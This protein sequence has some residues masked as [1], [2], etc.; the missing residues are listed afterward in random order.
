[1]KK[2]VTKKYLSHI[3]LLF[4]IPGLFVLFLSSTALSNPE[5][6]TE[7]YKKAV[8]KMDRSGQVKAETPVP[9]NIV[10]V[11]EDDQG[12]AF[13]TE[14]RKGEINRFRC[15]SCHNNKKVNIQNAAALSHAE[16][17][18]VHG[19]KEKPLSCDTCHSTEDRDFLTTEKGT[20]IDLDHVYEMCGQC[21]FRQKKDWIGGAHGKRITFWA[22]ERVVMNCTSCHNPHSPRM[23]A[24]W[25]KTYS[26][27]LK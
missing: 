14:T 1:M 16:I 26:V 15:S 7:Q 3:L 8:Q 5:G 4:V 6:V 27:P 25:P 10:R 23:A 20:K 21:H 18:V 17:K 11:L 2:T 13:F 9:K 12:G 24:G 19:Q 22:G